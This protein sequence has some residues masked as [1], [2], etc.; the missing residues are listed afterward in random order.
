M[1]TPVPGQDLH[2][3]KTAL[4]FARAR[5]VYPQAETIQA[6]LAELHRKFYKKEV[7]G[8]DKAE[9]GVIED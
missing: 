8:K 2:G 1:V 6:K 7:K 4:R 3:R 5:E 9:E